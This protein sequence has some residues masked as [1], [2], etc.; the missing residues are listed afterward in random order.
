MNPHERRNRLLEFLTAPVKPAG[1]ASR[2]NRRRRSKARVVLSWA[3][4]GEW[5]TVDGRLR[6][7]SRAG[8]GLF[9]AT[10]P[11]LTRLARLRLAEGDETPWIEA[12]ILG[13]EQ[14]RRRRY[15]VRLRFLNPCPSF[16]LQPAVLGQ[17]ATDDDRQVSPCEWVA[18]RPEESE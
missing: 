14:E 5:R 16:M 11:P 2:S 1:E 10:P 3:E 17:I 8:A 6:D 12:E 4:D 7:I 15:R 18:W 9:A 13:V